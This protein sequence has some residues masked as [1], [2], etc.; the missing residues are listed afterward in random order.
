MMNGGETLGNHT[1]KMQIFFSGRH[2]SFKD[3]AR[4]LSFDEFLGILTLRKNYK[5]VQ[6]YLLRKYHVKYSK[7]LIIGILI[8]VILAILGL[9]KKSKFLDYWD[10]Y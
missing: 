3:R 5:N 2:V 7:S 9:I 6:F 10:F 8:T 4:M 1:F